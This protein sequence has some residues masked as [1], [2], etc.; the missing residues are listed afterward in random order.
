MRHPSL[1]A[2]RYTSA[3]LRLL[4]PARHLNRIESPHH[5]SAEAICNG[6]TNVDALDALTGPWREHGLLMVP[7]A[8]R[9][10]A[11]RPAEL[12][13]LRT[14]ITYAE[15]FG[16]EPTWDQ[17]FER[18]RAIGLHSVMASL[19]YLN[20]VL[21]VK[22]T[23]NAQDDLVNGTFDEDL[24]RRLLR[25]AE[26]RGRI[27]YSPAQVLMVMKA[28][29]LHSPDREDERPD[30]EYGRLLAEVLLI[31]NDLLDP[32]ASTAAQA[33]QDRPE[34]MTALLAHSIRSTLANAHESYEPALAR[35]SVVFTDLSRRDDVRTHAGNDFM[36]DLEG[37]FGRLTGLTFRDYFAVGLAIVGW[38]RTGVE[39][40]DQVAHRKLS[41]GTYFFL[42]RLDPAIGVRLLERLTLTSAAA[43]EAFVE[44]EVGTRL[45]GYDVLPFM[46]RPL[47]RIRDDVTVP[48]SL[49]FLESA[50]TKGVYWLLF[51]AM[52]TDR[53]KLQFSRFYGH[54]LEAYVRD[55]VQRAFPDGAGL[56]RR[57][58]GDFA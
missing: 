39:H 22:G 19:S 7:A 58:F 3:G 2:P 4:T 36:D 28:A 8:F 23:L 53:K 41:P 44:R 14:R 6:S 47:Y 5:Q 35:A 11:S 34:L 15:L 27:V 42:T 46:G 16:A 9:A 30:G 20:S 40:R 29:I 49:A 54:L 55:V 31:A 37:Q 21:H 26:W 17:F 51:D 12:S 32:G 43:R 38:F 57:V 33:A 24:R 50:V 56:V 48:A 1:P 52:P 25:L 45:F 13:Y 10:P 18:L